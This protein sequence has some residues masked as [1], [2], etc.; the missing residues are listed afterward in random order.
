[1]PTIVDRSILEAQF[2]G[3]PD[4]HD[5]EV[6]AARLGSGRR[7]GGPP[8]LELDICVLAQSVTTSDGA[9]ESGPIV[10]TLRFEDINAVELSDFNHQNVLFDLVI[11]DVPPSEA[12]PR[13]ISVE[14][15][16]SWGLTGAFRCARIAVIA[17]KPIVSDTNWPASPPL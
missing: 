13:S 15:Q 3:W 12:D 6:D 5:A 11:R 14:L 16:S 7:G 2:G 8:T 4:F 1:M 10:A 17:A 9:R